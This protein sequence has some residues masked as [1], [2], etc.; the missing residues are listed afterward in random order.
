MFGIFN[1]F[2]MSVFHY[3]DFLIQNEDLE[4]VIGVP[5]LQY[6]SPLLCVLYPTCRNFKE[7]L[8]T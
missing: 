3:L 4:N 1:F 5:F 6:F 7:C 8:V 2:R